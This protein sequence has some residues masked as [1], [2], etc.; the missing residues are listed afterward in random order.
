MALRHRR[1]RR[2]RRAWRP[3]GWLP[4]ATAGV[5][6]LVCLVAGSAM[7]AVLPA[8]ERVVSVLRFA[9]G[10]YHL[11]QR[12]QQLHYLVITTLR[13]AGVPAAAHHV[14]D[15]LPRRRGG[16]R[17]QQRTHRVRVPLSLSPAALAARL[18]QV[19]QAAGYTA[20]VSHPRGSPAVVLR[21]GVADVTT[22]V[23]VLVPEAA[24][25]P[26]IA[27]VI[28]DVGW[29]PQAIA[30]L[31]ALEV[32]LSLAI[33]PETPYRAAIAQAA[34]QRG[35]DVLLHLPMEPAASTV[36]P[37]KY[38]LFSHMSA[39]ELTAQLEAALRALPAA[40]GVNNHMGSRF[41][42]NREAMR[43][44]LQ[45]LKRR[46]LFFLDSRTSPHS[47]AYRLARELGVPTAQ[48]HVFLDAEAEEGKIRQQLERLLHL[49][50]R[51]GSAIGIGHPYPETV[52]V[53]RQMVPQLRQAAVEFVPVSHLVH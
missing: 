22:D 42:E 17:W 48:R 29:D 25:R 32:P 24:T 46:R 28:D 49:A 52:A 36:P 26:R 10:H 47:Q 16:E 15:S 34:R 19:V 1:A 2:V 37:G 4:W 43:T 13:A 33:L 35:W 11:A 5:V 12:Q 50:R 27:I 44:V 45:Q 3:A 38:A 31:F 51:H 14:A 8:G 30:P 23:Y 20:S 41:T 7:L 9:L 40:V 39:A 6:A 53:L 21:L 18:Q